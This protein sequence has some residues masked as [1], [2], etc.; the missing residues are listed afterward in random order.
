MTMLSSAYIPFVCWNW[1]TQELI[2]RGV[3]QYQVDSNHWN[4]IAI[5]FLNIIDYSKGSSSIFFLFCFVLNLDVQM[6]KWL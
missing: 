5:V 1:D 3:G 4:C 2:W 6:K